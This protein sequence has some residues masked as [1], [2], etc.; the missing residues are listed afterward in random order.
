MQTVTVDYESWRK[1]AERIAAM[2]ERIADLESIL[3]T[4]A[5]RRAPHS[6]SHDWAEVDFARDNLD[7][8]GVMWT[9]Q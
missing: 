9:K 7:R 4:I 3:V 5:E 6:D 1:D 2:R 8:L